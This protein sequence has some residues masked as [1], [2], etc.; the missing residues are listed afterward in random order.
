M[1]PNELSDTRINPNEWRDNRENLMTDKILKE[2][3]NGLLGDQ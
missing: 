2:V 3:A 1:N